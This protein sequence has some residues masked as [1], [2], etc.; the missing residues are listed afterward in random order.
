MSTGEI[1]GWILFTII[2]TLLFFAAFGGSSYDEDSIEEYM[3]NI[4]TDIRKGENR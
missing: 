3:E 2:I 4:M 1:F